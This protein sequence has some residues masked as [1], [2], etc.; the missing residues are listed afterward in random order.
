MPSLLDSSNSN[1]CSQI[2]R[3]I[4]SQIYM[5]L[6][7]LHVIFYR[8]RIQT[9]LLISCDPLLLLTPLTMN[10]SIEMEMLLWNTD[11]K[12]STSQSIGFHSNKGSVVPLSLIMYCP[13]VRSPR[14]RVL[15]HNPWPLHSNQPPT[16][17]GAL[18]TPSSLPLRDQITLKPKFT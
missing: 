5:S 11:I 7:P 1:W 10:L 12:N 9:K 16:P 14:R 8:G 2:R 4:F 17:Q 3:V 15:Y 6:T 18:F 13:R